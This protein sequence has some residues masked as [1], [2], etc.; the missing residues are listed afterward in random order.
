MRVCLFAL[1]IACLCAAPLHAAD[2]SCG[3]GRHE[4]T[5]DLWDGYRA[6]L[7][8]AADGEHAG[9]CRVAVVSAA[10]ATVFEA[11]GTQAALEPATEHDVNDDGLKDAV[12]STATQGSYSYYVVTL[13]D[14]LRVMAQ[15]TTSVPL[16]FEDRDGDGRLEIWARD[17][18]F[19]RFDD[20]PAELTPQPLIIFR[21]KGETLHMVSQAFWPDYEQEIAQAKGRISKDI[22]E[23]FSG[24][25][26]AASDS[27]SKPKE[28]SP[29]EKEAVV[30][31]KA[32]ALGIVLAYLYGGRGQEAWKALDDM[33]PPL[34]KPR[35]RQMILKARTG[36]ILSEINRPKK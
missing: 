36:G 15:Y 14:P 18:A 24:S 1:A 10:G 35:I 11:Y 8:P 32:E 21:L 3:P 20:L 7:A 2:I 26:T 31:V 17:F 28:L 5:K 22:L 6:S 19:L 27:D 13:A 23:K 16:H 33:W 30:E 25:P 34:D 9:Q 12:I 29:H 4:V